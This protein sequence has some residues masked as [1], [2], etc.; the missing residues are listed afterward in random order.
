MNTGRNI[1]IWA[2]HQAVLRFWLHFCLY[3]FSENSMLGTFSSLYHETCFQ[4]QSDQHTVNS[5]NQLSCDT[6]ENT[7]PLCCRNEAKISRI[8]Q[9]WCWGPAP[10]SGLIRDDLAEV[11]C[12]HMK[13]RLLNLQSFKILR[14]SSQY[15][16]RETSSN[17][18][19]TCVSGS[20]G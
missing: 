9:P 18:K 10:T 2:S 16:A 15:V 17:E 4:L 20:C 6:M 14:P 19:L 3:K 11:A 7:S 1:S 12:W 5:L 13:L 8:V